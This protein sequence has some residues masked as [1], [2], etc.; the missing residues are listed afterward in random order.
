V[1]LKL[2]SC[3]IFYREICAAVARSPHRVDVEFLPKGLHDIGSEKMLARLQERIDLVDASEHET[4]LLGYGLCNRG[5]TGLRARAIPLVVP[6]AH[7]CITLFFGSLARQTEYYEKHPGAYFLTSGW[8]ERGAEL[9]SLGPASIQNQLGLN[10]SYASLVEKYGEEDAKELY[11][12]LGDMLHNY[13]RIAFIEMGV[14]K[15]LGFEDEARRQATSK[16]WEFEKIAGDAAWLQRLVSGPWDSPQFLVV[17]KGQ[18][19]VDRHDGSLVAA[20]P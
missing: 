6:R 5:I 18:R 20:A 7:D 8:I 10:A 13:R 11:A 2:I 15:G 19:I 16:G 17:P 12:E 9:G 4:I 3:E 14:E 1:K